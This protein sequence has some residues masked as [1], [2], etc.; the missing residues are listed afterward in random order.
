MGS[1]RVHPGCTDISSVIPGRWLNPSEPDTEP[2][3]LRW[4]NE[5]CFMCRALSKEK[6]KLLLES[7]GSPMVYRQGVL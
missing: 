4:R 7:P 3:G 5:S 1:A 6:G 2:R